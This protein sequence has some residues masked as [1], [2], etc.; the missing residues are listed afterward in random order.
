[1]LEHV[2]LGQSRF[3]TPG[4]APDPRGILLGRLA[5]LLFPSLDGVVSWLRLYSAES[6]LDELMPGLSIAHVRTPLGSHEMVVQLPATTSYTVD[7]AAR[8]ARLVGGSTFTGTTKHFV[9]YRDERSPYGYDATDV[10]SLPQGTDFALHGDDFFQVYRRESEIPF[11]RILFRLSVRK[12]QPG[13]QGHPEE[14]RDLFLLVARGLGPAVIRYLWR[15]EVDA[16]LAL[17][18]PRRDAAFSVPG[19]YLLFRCAELPQRV[20]TLFLDT[21]GIDVFRQVLSN[22]AVQA[23]HAHPLDLSSCASA[24]AADSF[25]LFHG[26]GRVEI[27]AGPLEL[28]A[29]DHL[30]ELRLE[31]DKAAELGEF[32]SERGEPVGVEL[33]LAPSVTPPRNVV[34]TLVPLAQAGWIKR[35]VYLLPPSSLRGHRV[36]VTERGILLLGSENLDVIP[37]GELL[38]ELAPG[39]LVPV[40]MELVPRVH[41]EVLARTLGHGSGLYTVFPHGGPPFQL[42]DAALVP[43]ERR[44]IARLAVSRAEIVDARVEVDGD[45]QVVNDPVGRFAL[46]GF[47]PGDAG[48]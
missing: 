6:S 10:H 42:G 14:R 26:N 46:W 22:V 41:P 44:A 8:C 33:R 39:L 34:G 29:V 45:P 43:L 17:L 31:L 21:P 47:R 11:D 23:G 1:M 38:S 18:A 37:L 25:Y 48:R 28:S 4:V 3:V 40:G 5:L 9:K 32:R 15:N 13:L 7:R 24:F 12:I 36:A 19:S 2:A 30:T 20:L 35:L 27:V 16:R